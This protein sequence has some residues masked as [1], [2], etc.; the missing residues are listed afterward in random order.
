[1]GD[2]EL[3]DVLAQI[4]FTDR[5]SH[6]LVELFQSVLAGQKVW[7]AAERLSALHDPTWPYEFHEDLQRAAKVL[8]S[9]WCYQGQS[10]YS[11]VML[12]VMTACCQSQCPGMQRTSGHH[13]PSSLAV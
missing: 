5:V 11:V 9:A 8:A 12:P 7:R 3:A 2:E 13:S 4:R 1:M 6:Y 10:C